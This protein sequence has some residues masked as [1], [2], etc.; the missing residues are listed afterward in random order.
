MKTRLLFFA[1]FLSIITSSFGQNYYIG[2]SVGWHQDIFTLS[3]TNKHLSTKHIDI[4][5]PSANLEFSVLFENGAEVSTGVGYY[6]FLFTPTM[7]LLQPIDNI[8]ALS[9]GLHVAHNAISIPI[10]GGYNINLWKKRL[11]LKVQSGFGFDI[12]FDEDNGQGEGTE[13]H[14]NQSMSN[15]INFE[16]PI[17]THFN[18]LISNKIS[19]Q[20]FTKFGMGISIFGAY[21]AGLM[22]VWQNAYG[23][24]D[25]NN[26]EEVLD[27][28]IMSNGSYWQFGIELGYKF[29]KKKKKQ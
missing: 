26:G 6:R 29:G 24:F 28:K 18:V 1:L 13:A 23:H 11:L 25:W 9:T 12:Y 16:A 19:L 3:E 10:T 2:A 22:R 7:F 15:I 8:T 4:I 17:E 21:H 5:N 27:T 20:Y 14:E